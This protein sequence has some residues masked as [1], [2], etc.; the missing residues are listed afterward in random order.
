MSTESAAQ[1]RHPATSPFHR[2]PEPAVKQFAVNDRVLHD[3]YGLGR[4]VAQEVGA[5]SVDFGSTRVRVLSPFLRLE[6]L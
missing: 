2:S 6:K 1:R 4:V 3:R 5:V